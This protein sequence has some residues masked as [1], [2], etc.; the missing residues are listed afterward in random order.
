MSSAANCQGAD[1]EFVSRIIG[2]LDATV[3]GAIIARDAVSGRLPR[4]E[5]HGK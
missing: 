4:D 1:D 2:Q 3:Q 5:A